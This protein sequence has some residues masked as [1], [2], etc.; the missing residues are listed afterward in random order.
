MADGWPERLLSHETARD[1]RDRASERMRCEFAAVAPGAGSAMFTRGSC[2][3]EDG[4]L[5]FVPADSG[6]GRRIELGDVRAAAHQSRKLTEQ[7]QLTTRDEVVAMNILTDDG[8]R[9]SREHAIDLWSALR[10][11]G[12]APGNGFRIVE[13][14]PAG[15]TTW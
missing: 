12:V 14:Y 8:S 4:R 7:L 2:G 3:I 10:R 6:V 15:A 13:A 1:A 9:K 11:E 5:T